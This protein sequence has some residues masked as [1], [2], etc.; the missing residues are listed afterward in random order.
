[1][2]MFTGFVTA[3]LLLRNRSETHKRLMF[4]ATVALLDAVTERLPGLTHISPQAHYWVVD[5]F[6]VC[7]VAYDLISMRRVNPA[8]IWGALVIFTLPPASRL[9]FQFAVPHL[10]GVDPG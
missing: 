6:V 1:M 9:I 7:G 3:G 4:L 2:F 5:L 8:Y 10:V